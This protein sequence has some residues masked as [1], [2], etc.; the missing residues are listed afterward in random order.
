[1]ELL[2]KVSGEARRFRARLVATAEIQAR[3]LK[4]ILARN[5]GCEYG[6]RHGF[7]HIQNYAQFRRSVPTVK[8]EDLRADIDRMA[9]GSAD[10]LTAS[11]V[12]AFEETGGSAG[13]RKLIPHTRASLE[14][15][16]RALRVW[17]DDLFSHEPRLASGTA[18]WAI[19]PACRAPRDCAA[20]VPIGLNDIEYFGEEMAGDV[21]RL[22]SVPPSVGALSDFDEWRS[23]TTAHLLA[24]EHLTWFSIW[25][26]AFLQ[27]LLRCVVERGAD[28]VARYATRQRVAHVRAALATGTI[29][30]RRI[31]PD[32]RLISCWDQAASRAPARELAASFPGVTLQGKGLLATEGVISIPLQGSRMPVLA[33]ESGFYEFVAPDGTVHSAA[34]LVRGEAYEILLTNDSGLYRY[35]IGDRVR[36]HEFVGGAP[37]VEFLGRSGVVSDLCGEKLTEDFVLAALRGVELGFCALAAD[38]DRYVLLLDAD[39]VAGHDVARLSREIDSALELNPQYAYARSLGQLGALTPKFCTGPMESFQADA[40]RR[41]RRLGDIK[42]PALCTGSEWRRAFN[43]VQS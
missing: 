24:D 43:V 20:G 26:P 36:V 12:L 9:N 35:A 15:F 17:L 42:T 31:W 3:M 40:L 5:A 27:I 11:A 39:E 7:D 8:Y 16:R 23:T 25:S 1:M 4:D 41:G 32:L 34:E 18:Y 30:F 14:A 22:L 21:L 37:A 28:L 29:D 10:V 13:G 2:R 6:R 19:S 33:V 38:S